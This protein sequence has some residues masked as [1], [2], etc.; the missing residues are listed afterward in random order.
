MATML[1]RIV[2]VSYGIEGTYGAG[3]PDP[4]FSSCNLLFRNGNLLGVDQEVIDLSELRAGL[5]KSG[6]AIGRTLYKITPGHVLMGHAGAPTAFRLGRLLRMCGMQ[7][8]TNASSA[9]YAFRSSGF[10]SGVVKVELGGTDA[11]SITAI[12]KG[13]YGNVQFAGAAGQPI[14]IDATVTGT[15]A[16]PS[17]SGSSA[18]KSLPSNTVQTMKNVGLVV[19][20]ETGLGTDTFSTPVSPTLKFKSFSL[21]LG[22]DIQEDKDAN[23]ADAL[24]GLL[25]ANRRPT[26]QIVVGLDSTLYD[27]FI[28]Q[29]QGG[30]KHKVTFTHGSGTGKVCVFTW[31]GQITNV[32]LQ[33][34]VGLRT[35]AISYNLARATDDAELSLV[36]S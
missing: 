23:A 2:A 8:T 15:F 36:F 27:D 16:V 6:D 14:T 21:D 20:P 11:S 1:N 32:E 35:A 24:F 18:S 7:E 13:A 34:D 5:T 19:T 25:L 33:D 22:M 3:T 4:A 17:Y 30:L 26:A 28:A 10:E 31:Y 9:T 12:L 29:M